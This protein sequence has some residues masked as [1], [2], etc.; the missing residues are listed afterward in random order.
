MNLA[1]HYMILCAEAKVGGTGLC[2]PV[3]AGPG[4]GRVF[5]LCQ[6]QNEI[7]GVWT[8]LHRSRPA[9]PVFMAA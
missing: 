5:L 2:A 9:P 8:C 3:C 6:S 4:Q 7:S 1:I